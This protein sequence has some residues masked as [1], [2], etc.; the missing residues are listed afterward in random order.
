MINVTIKIIGG[1]YSGNTW[2]G[3]LHDAPVTM[4]IPEGIVSARTTEAAKRMRAAVAEQLDRDDRVEINAVGWAV[5][6]ERIADGGRSSG[7]DE[8]AADQGPASAG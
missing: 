5:R 7:E 2:S 3:H 8:I 4:L 1:T 6:V